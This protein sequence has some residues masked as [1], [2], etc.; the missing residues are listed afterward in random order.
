MWRGLLSVV[1]GGCCWE[2]WVVGILC[3]RGAEAWERVL[4]VTRA[5]CLAGVLLCDRGIVTSV[6]VKYSDIRSTDGQVKLR[7]LSLSSFA[8]EDQLD[9]SI[10]LLM[11]TVVAANH[12][13]TD[14]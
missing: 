10:R 9:R 14:L 1:S 12:R 4:Q 7:G 11:Y 13:V 2:C 6:C 5:M 3:Y 8:L